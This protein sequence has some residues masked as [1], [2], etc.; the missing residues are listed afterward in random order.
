MILYYGV[1]HYLLSVIDII[2]NESKIKGESKSL[3][4]KE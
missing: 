4:N 2:W 3:T 1:L